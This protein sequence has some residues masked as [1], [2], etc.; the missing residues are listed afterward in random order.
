MNKTKKLNKKLICIVL[1]F[2]S[3]FLILFSLFLLNYVSLEKKEIDL[4]LK[5][6]EIAAFNLDKNIFSFGTITPNVTSSREIVLE[7]NYTF[8]IKVNFEIKGEI[9]R[10]IL[11]ENFIQLK[12]N[13]TKTIKLETIYPVKEDFGEYFGKLIVLFKRDLIKKDI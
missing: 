10:F 3:L 9:K 7:N 4:Q 8:P 12:S 1:F 5:I 2:I 6:G 11:F 13:E